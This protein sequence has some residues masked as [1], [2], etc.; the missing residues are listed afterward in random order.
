MLTVVDDEYRKLE[1]ERVVGCGV[2]LCR[3]KKN[4]VWEHDERGIWRKRG[5]GEL[6]GKWDGWREFPEGEVPEIKFARV[7]FCRAG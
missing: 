3:T 2:R 6:W 1:W 5:V 4:G 7:G